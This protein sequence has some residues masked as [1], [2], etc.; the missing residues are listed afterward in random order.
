M[1]PEERRRAIVDLVNKDKSVLVKDLVKIFGVTNET[2]RRDLIRLEKEGK[3]KKGHGGAYVDDSVKNDIHVNIRETVY[4]KEKDKIGYSASKLVKDGDAI[5]LDGST[6]SFYILKHLKNKENLTIITNSLKISNV[7]SKLNHMD[8]FLLGGKLD[9]I[10][11]S[12]LGEDAKDILNNYFV[13][14]SFV[15]CRGVS[16]DAGITDGNPEQGLL[17]RKMLERGKRKVLVLD[18]TKF[19]LTSFYLISEF[20]NIDDVI[21]D[22]P[23]NSEW[24]NFFEKKEINVIESD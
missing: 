5:I 3:L 24:K 16:M 20:E 19:D 18:K 9:H 10:T 22:V 17:R 4:I 14:I 2:I 15:S 23:L 6:T 21:V 7:V 1:F 11:G 12:F 8:L 13:D